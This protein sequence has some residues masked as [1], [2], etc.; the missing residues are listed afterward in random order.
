MC[1]NAF[2]I[3]P[4]PKRRRSK[5]NP[6]RIFTVGPP[7]DLH[8]YLSFVDSRGVSIC[9]EI[10]KQLYTAF[11]QFERDDLS[12]MNEMD[13]H[14]ERLELSD[15]AL[16]RRAVKSIEPIEDSIERKMLL[17]S[18]LN[19][20]TPTQRR[21]LCL[22]HLYGLRCEE[23]AAMEGCSIQSVSGSIKMA[24]KKIKKFLSTP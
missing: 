23:I 5:D 7:N 8:Y 11:D 1:N 2:E 3:N 19:I 9:M 18:A 16:W 22:R 13:R 17:H 6:Y 20:L 14:Y 12:Y 24:E 15:I 21:R 4:S 10:S